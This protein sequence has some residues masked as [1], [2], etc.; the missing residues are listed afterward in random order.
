MSCQLFC[1]WMGIRKQIYVANRKTALAS[2]LYHP[3]SL[4]HAPLFPC[5]IVI[6]LNMSIIF[7]VDLCPVVFNMLACCFLQGEALF[8]L[9]TGVHRASKPVLL[10]IKETARLI[11][12]LSLNKDFSLCLDIVFSPSYLASVEFIVASVLNLSGPKARGCQN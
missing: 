1:V 2:F 8:S 3:F 12:S 5:A 9:W 10:C 6:S 7:S 4:P 11:L